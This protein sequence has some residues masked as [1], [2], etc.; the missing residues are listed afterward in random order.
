MDL[1]NLLTHTEKGW[2]RIAAYFFITIASCITI[3]FQGKDL[4]K[5]REKVE[6]QGVKIEVI[7]YKTKN[8]DDGINRVE[9]KTDDILKILIRR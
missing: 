5:L 2:V 4:P 7:E 3:L 8:L 6:A 9:R 1:A